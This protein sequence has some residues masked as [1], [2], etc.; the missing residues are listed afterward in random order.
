VALSAFSAVFINGLLGPKTVPVRT[1]ILSFFF[2]F[3]INF[4]FLVHFI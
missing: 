4:A 2:A 1:H 3:T